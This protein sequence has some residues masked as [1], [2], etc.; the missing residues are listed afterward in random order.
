MVGPGEARDQNPATNRHERPV[1]NQPA[2][3]NQSDVMNQSDMN[4]VTNEP[5]TNSVE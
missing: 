1:M 5:V 3:K 4:E 2:V